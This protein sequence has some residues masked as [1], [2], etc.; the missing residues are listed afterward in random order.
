MLQNRDYVTADDIQSVA[1]AVVGVR[2][3]VR[4]GTVQSAIENMIRAVDVQSTDRFI[5]H[6]TEAVPCE[7]E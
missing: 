2:L 6:E 7:L 3:V 1:E 4:S 5:L